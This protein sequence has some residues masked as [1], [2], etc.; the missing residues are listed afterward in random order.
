MEE[1]SARPP[2]I[3]SRRFGGLRVPGIFPDLP[4]YFLARSGESWLAA[5]HRDCLD[6]D[7]KE[8]SS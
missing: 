1:E 2:L 8:R 6:I 7:I 3:P 5:R 4:Q